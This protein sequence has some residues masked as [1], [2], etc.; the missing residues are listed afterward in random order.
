MKGILMTLKKLLTIC[1]IFLLTSLNINAQTTVPILW[2]FSLSS[3][4]ATMV[5]T[6]VDELNTVQK[7]YI[8]VFMHKPGAGGSIAANTLLTQQGPIIMAATSSFFIRPNLY[9]SASHD[10]SKFN[11]I[12]T[13]CNNQPLA[14]FSS[15]YKTL[16]E[17]KNNSVNI[18]V[19]PGSITHLTAIAYGQSSKSNFNT[20]FY[21]GTPEITKDVLGGHL[22]VSVDFLS[23]ASQFSGKINV[24]GISGISDYPEGRTF[25]SQGITGVDGTH[26]NFLIYANSTDPKLINIIRHA[27]ANVLQSR[28]LQDA[29]RQEYGSVVTNVLSSKEA[30]E[31]YTE[32]TNFWRNQ[33]QGLVIEK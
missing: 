11:T 6:I 4:H 9:P 3:T 12:G 10:L 30:T 26:S 33:S 5:R 24:L 2:P 16:S 20:I 28:R 32:Q 27:F 8:F 31:L 17:I 25:K 21:Q 13:Y 15:K 22:D 1:S 19:I 14:L 23:S 29:C 18:G 7:D